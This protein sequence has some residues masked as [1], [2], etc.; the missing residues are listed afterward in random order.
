DADA[1]AAADDA[2]AADADADADAAD[3]DA[4]A[5]AAADAEDVDDAAAA[6]AVTQRTPQM[7]APA[8]DSPSADTSQDDA[9]PAE[10]V[11]P[12]LPPERPP[13]DLLPAGGLAGIPWLHLAAVAI[14]P[15]LAVIVLLSG[16]IEAAQERFGGGDPFEPN[17]TFAEAHFI[18]GGKHTGISLLR[19]DIDW[20]RIKVDAG[21]GLSVRYENIPDDSGVS[22]HG[23]S[24]ARL[25]HVGES[26]GELTYVP[27]DGKSEEVFLV[28]SGSSRELVTIEIRQI[29]PRQRFE[30]N[31]TPPQA[32]NIEPGAISSLTCDG[33]DWFRTIVPAYRSLN[34]SV[35]GGL[36]VR[37]LETADAAGQAK[38]ALGLP[39]KASVSGH[40][41]PR[42]VLIQ[43]AGRGD[44]TLD[45]QLGV[46]ERERA[47]RNGDELETYNTTLEPN[48]RREE[49]VELTPGH[50]PK[51]S[52]N[53]KDYYF[54]NIPAGHTLT[55]EWRGSPSIDFPTLRSRIFGSD[56]DSSG[57]QVPLKRRVVYARRK[58][59]LSVLASGRGDY[60]LT[61]KITPG[62]P[63]RELRPGSY[64]QIASQGQ[65]LFRIV[66][67]AG[68]KLDLDF[69]VGPSDRY[70]RQVECR[71][72]R[73]SLDPKQPRATRRRGGRTEYISGIETVTQRFF[74]RELLFI[75][76]RG[77][78][79]PYDLN[80]SMT[81]N[82]AKKG[83]GTFR[84]R[85][86]E[87]VGPG[88][89]VG[90]NV[91]RGV[92][93]ID[94]AAND[95]LEASVVFS[96]QQGDLDL[97]LLD[98]H[99]ELLMD[100]TGET[101]EERVSAKVRADQR[102][103]L[104][105][106]DLSGVETTYDLEIKINGKAVPRGDLTPITKGIHRGLVCDRETLLPISVKKGQRVRAK[107]SFDDEKGELDLGILEADGREQDYQP[108][109]GPSEELEYD[110]ERDGTIYLR[111]SGEG[112]RFDLELA[113]QDP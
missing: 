20:F 5:L 11:D 83:L 54:V 88:T 41:L 65:D 43:V 55:L 106:R 105:V 31:D 87:V 72:L 3:A 35:A 104:F 73:V 95:E 90:R 80:V 30:E 14:A 28:L 46:V 13:A 7:E 60:P 77:A 102:V 6:A 23:P 25:E 56:L 89:Y 78:R 75:R 45:L 70:G 112:K 17:D 15:A 2:D 63:G 69:D 12:S 51:L 59:K 113:I 82:A 34:V 38:A 21:R 22:L 50:Y 32:A 61:C 101:D 48:D 24:G 10:T 8:S 93:G 76:V 86:F 84:P 16:G 96:S 94:L 9:S 67:D 4:A 68:D 91:E 97:E 57:G 100:S 1:D 49:A 37:L 58:L 42:H 98:T 53:R 92:Y 18:G 79:R 44:Y 85:T 111:V 66:G 107:I 81:K 108:Q 39:A 62:L 52:C 29:D 99:G 110:V 71:L 47:R 103:Y 19:D 109:L 26:L 40:Q 64:P 33:S 74:V 36:G 27:T